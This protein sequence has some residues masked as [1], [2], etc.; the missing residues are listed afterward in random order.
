VHFRNE[1]F[2]VE[3]TGKNNRSFVFA[4]TGGLGGGQLGGDDTAFVLLQAYGQTKHVPREP[5]VVT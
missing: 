4:N 1:P 3:L 5:I 2:I